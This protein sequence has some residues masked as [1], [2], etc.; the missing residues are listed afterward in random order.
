LPIEYPAASTCLNAVAQG[1]LLEHLVDPKTLSDA[2]VR[3]VLGLFFDSIF[4]ADR[5]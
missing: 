3:Q 4:E 2:A 1:L 5:A